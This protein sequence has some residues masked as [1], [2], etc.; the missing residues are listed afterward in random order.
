MGQEGSAARYHRYDCLA[1]GLDLALLGYSEPLFPVEHENRRQRL[2]E[3]EGL[4][5]QLPQRPLFL[6]QR[7]LQFPD[8]GEGVPVVLLGLRLW[9]QRRGR[10]RIW[11]SRRDRK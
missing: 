9:R 8:Y 10:E 3:D 7:Q 6:R 1:E 11:R 5:Q 2:C 4:L